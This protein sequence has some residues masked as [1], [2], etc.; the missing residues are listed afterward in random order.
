VLV[1]NDEQLVVH[2]KYIRELLS[3]IFEMY[4]ESAESNLAGDIRK[5]I[6]KLDEALNL[7]KCRK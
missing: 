2:E 6:C 5:A 7:C 3:T 1:L 4:Y